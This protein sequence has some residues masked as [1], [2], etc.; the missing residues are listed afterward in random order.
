MHILSLEDDSHNHVKSNTLCIDRQ[1][2]HVLSNSTQSFLPNE[3]KC[4]IHTQYFGLIT[5]DINE[6]NTQH[7]LYLIQCA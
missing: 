3:L 2:F 1:S 5:H 4:Y 6:Q 7:Q